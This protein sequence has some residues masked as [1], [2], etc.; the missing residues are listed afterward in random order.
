MQYHTCDLCEGSY[1]TACPNYPSPIKT[2]PAVA[3]ERLWDWVEGDVAT[4][5]TLLDIVQ[6]SV[7]S[8]LTLW[9]LGA[10]GDEIELLDQDGNLVADC[11]RQH[12]DTF[13]LYRRS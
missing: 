13:N 2:E 5:V 1:S 11:F 3:D 7:Q 12:A 6:R 9:C 4:S 8:G 10:K